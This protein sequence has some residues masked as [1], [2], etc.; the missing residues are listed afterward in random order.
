M[1]NLSEFEYVPGGGWLSG[2]GVDK[3]SLETDI[4]IASLQPVPRAEMGGGGVVTS[5]IQTVALKRLI[6][7]WLHLPWFRFPSNVLM[8]SWLPTCRSSAQENVLVSVMSFPIA[9]EGLVLHLTQH[10]GLGYSESLLV[11]TLPLLVKSG[12]WVGKASAPP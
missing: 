9:E 1:G 8:I 5:A 2:G 7:N 3:D 11:M 6:M 12:F 10:Q 4:G